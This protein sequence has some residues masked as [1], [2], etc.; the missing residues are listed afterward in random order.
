MNRSYLDNQTGAKDPRREPRTIQLLRQS[1]KFQMIIGDHQLE[2]VE[3]RDG[4]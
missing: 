1:H 4:R 2:R 3:G